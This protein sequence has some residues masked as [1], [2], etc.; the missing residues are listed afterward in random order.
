MGFTRS[1]TDI[2]VHQKLGDYPN[3]D[4]GLSAEELKKRFDM[5]A[6]TVQ[7]D[8]NKLIEELESMKG[9]SY[10]NSEQVFPT[11][12]SD[13]DIL[14]KLKML[15]EEI[16]GVTQGAIPDGSIIEAKLDPVFSEKLAR[17]NGNLQ[18]NLNAELFGGLRLEDMYNFVNGGIVIG[19]YTGNYK[20]STS[21]Q[22]INIG[23]KPKAVI[24]IG[25]DN[26]IGAIANAISIIINTT[27]YV[28]ISGGAIHSFSV[29]LTDKGIILGERM[30]RNGYGYNY[31]AFR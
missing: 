13:N 14:S 23:F 30:N 25:S 28:A 7:K 24:I 9:A 18:V 21:T 12:L 16:Q 5:P 31:I 4:N 17:R 15:H 26:D 29:Q 6:E 20:S 22:E 2:S 1:T 19:T 11:D 10:I 27:G 8:L 3:Q